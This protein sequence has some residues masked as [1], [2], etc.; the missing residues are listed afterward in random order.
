MAATL[1][2]IRFLLVLPAQSKPKSSGRVAR[3]AWHAQTENDVIRWVLDIV[4]SQG[5]YFTWHSAL[6]LQWGSDHGIPLPAPAA[7]PGDQ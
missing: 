1:F 6:L 4:H 3:L 5:R 2:M 7:V